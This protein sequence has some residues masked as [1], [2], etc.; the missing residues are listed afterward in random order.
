[1]ISK[2]YNNFRN[3]HNKTI[4]FLIYL[5]LFSPIFITYAINQDTTFKKPE[6]FLFIF[7][8]IVTLLSFLAI[9]LVYYYNFFIYKRMHENKFAQTS[10]LKKIFISYIYIIFIFANLFYMT[11]YMQNISTTKNIEKENI[12]YFNFERANKNNYINNFNLYV[13]C[14]YLSITTITTIGYGEVISN[15]TYGKFLIAV[16]A[17][18][19]QIM[20]GL[21]MTLWFVKKNTETE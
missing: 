9:I 8:A 13:D 12:S 3:I 6:Q 5:F 2:I 1:M 15:Y 14:V 20:W 7:V 18:I 4:F 16:E 17:M 21:S 11:Q 19:G 10:H